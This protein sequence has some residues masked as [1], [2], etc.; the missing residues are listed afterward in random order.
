MLTGLTSAFVSNVSTD[1][2]VSAAVSEQVGVAAGT[3]ID[4]LSVDE[5][6]ALVEDA[7]VD[8]STADAIVDDYAQAQ[9]QALKTGMLVA[10]L[11]ALLSLPFTRDLPRISARDEGQSPTTEDAAT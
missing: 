9:I 1:E 5:V 3:G 7:D 2:R 10:A 6:R 11:L 4:F 8:D